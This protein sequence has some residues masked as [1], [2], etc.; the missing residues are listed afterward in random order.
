MVK[1]EMAWQKRAKEKEELEKQE[2]ERQ[3]AQLEAQH[4]SMSQAQAAQAAMRLAAAIALRNSAPPVMNTVA[5]SPTSSTVVLGKGAGKSLRPMPATAAGPHLPRQRVSQAPVF[6][7]AI[8]WKG[9][10]GWIR[11]SEPVDHPMRAKHGGKIY[12]SQIDLIGTRE[13]AVGQL[14]YFHVYSDSSGL[15]AEECQVC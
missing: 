5:G 1:R 4:A 3:K 7:E 8:E 15:G 9:K 2:K 10:F 14:C 11:P 6:G 13:L 12:I